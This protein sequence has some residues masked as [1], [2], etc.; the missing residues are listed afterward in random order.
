MARNR[1]EIRASRSSPVR[2]VEVAS[3]EDSGRSD[4]ARGTGDHAPSRKPNFEQCAARWCRSIS[5][6]GRDLNVSEVAG[7][8]PNR[9]AVAAHGGAEPR[10][11]GKSQPGV[12]GKAFAAFVERAIEHQ[13]FAAVRKVER[14]RRVRRPALLT[15]TSAT[16]SAA[17]L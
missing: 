10:L 11:R 4:G 3:R 8:D 7:L 2:P 17:S 13:K 9:A 14:N 16:K 6:S 5:C 12:R 15:I 1:P